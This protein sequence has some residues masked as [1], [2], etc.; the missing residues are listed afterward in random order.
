MAGRI[1]PTFLEYMLHKSEENFGPFV[2][3]DCLIEYPGDN[4]LGLVLIE[5]K[6][7]PPGLAVPGGMGERMTLAENAVKEAFEETGLEFK[8]TDN[9]D[10]PFLVLSNPKQ[11]KRAFII[12]VA[13]RGRGYGEIAPMKHEDAKSA[14]LYTFA[15]LE[16]FVK[17]R[18]AWAFQHHRRMVAEYLEVRRR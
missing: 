11:D 12:S 8:I 14:R 16:G 10:K 1:F 2:A 18:E 6:D 7:G 15:E 17:V 9:P 4:P 5:R 3:T 13:Y